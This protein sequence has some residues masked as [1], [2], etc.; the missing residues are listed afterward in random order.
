[1]TTPNVS[2]SI[3]GIGGSSDNPP[4]NNPAAEGDSME[5]VESSTGITGEGNGQEPENGAE[6][7]SG[8]AQPPPEGE[9][10]AE[11]DGDRMEVEQRLS[12]IDYLKSPVVIL[13][14]GSPPAE[15]S[16]SCHL[17]LLQHS[18]WFAEHCSSFTHSTPAAE[19]LVTLPNDELTAVGSFL[20][21]LYTGE[22]APRLVPNPSGKDQ[23]D[24]VLENSNDNDLDEDGESLLKHARV[25]TLAERLGVSGLKTLAHSKIHRINSTAKGELKYARFVYANTPRDDKTIRQ[26]IASFW[27]HRSHVLR[28][29]A[30]DEFRRM[31]LEFPQFA[32]DILSIVLDQKE[33]GK[34]SRR[35]AP[36]GDDDGALVPHTPAE[37]VPRSGR[38]RPRT[39]TLA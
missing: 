34:E 20:E 33:K 29:E 17:A 35:T 27:A 22:Y 14:V 18:P 24:L 31:V 7:G 30:E 23:N 19:R 1:M 16:L 3:P 15:T 8:D 26:P 9:G 36:A 28:H 21:F 38:K 2:V 4:A 25:Y 11:G 32:Y 5:G 12:Y 10:E 39:S 13:Q 6:N 37:K